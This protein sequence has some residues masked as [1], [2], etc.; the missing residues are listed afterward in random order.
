MDDG[1]QK[2]ACLRPG[3]IVYEQNHGDTYTNCVLQ[4]QEHGLLRSRQAAAGI[5]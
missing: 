1:P 5:W 2:K 3:T 4:N